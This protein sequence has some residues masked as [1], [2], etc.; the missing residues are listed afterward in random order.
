M[1]STQVRRLLQDL[2]NRGRCAQPTHQGKAENPV[3]GDVVEIHLEIGNEKILEC[4][5][6]AYGCPG[7]LAAGAGLTELVKGRTLESC[8]ALD[9]ESLLEFLGGLPR[10]KEHG[11]ELALTAF[12]N[13][14]SG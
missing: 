12:R 2:P 5:F 9:V 1:Y 11:A 4:R 10:Q 7:A 6:Q 13:A 3:C 14:L 8:R